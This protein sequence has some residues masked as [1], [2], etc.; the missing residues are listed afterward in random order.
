MNF[1]LC[2]ILLLQYTIRMEEIIL[3]HLPWFWLAVMVICILIESFT[4]ALTTIWFGIGAVIM[5][6]I[7][8]TPLD[9]K[10]Q[11]LLFTIISCL[12][13]VFTRPF[14]VK[15]LKNG[16]TKTNVDALVGMETVV[17]KTIT[18]FDKGEIKLNNTIWT[19]QSD[20]GTEIPVGTECLVTGIDGA[21]AKVVAIRNTVS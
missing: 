2:I 8:L 20:D 21:T 5:V 11:L 4:L 7:S 15:K 1:K 19:A 17:T 18:K 9:F 16:T 13:L 14:A 10:W 12:L 3:A 6:F